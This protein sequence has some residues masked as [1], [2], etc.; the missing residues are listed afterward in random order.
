MK[1]VTAFVGS[2]RKGNTYDAVV[3]F[4]GNLKAMGDIETEIVR[5]SEY[6]LGVCRGCRLCFD[7]GE[8]HCPYKDDRDVLIEKMIASDGVVFASPNYSFQVS[9]LMKVFLDR[10]GFGFHRPRFFGKTYTSIVTQGIYGGGK[11][12]DY[13]DFVGNALGFN[14]VKGSCLMMLL[15]MTE[16]Q[17]KKIDR[18]LADQAR[19]YYTTLEKPGYPVPAV[20]L[21]VVLQDGPNEDKAG[22]RRRQSRLTP[23]IRTRAGWNLISTIPLTWEC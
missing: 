3:Q 23:T 12:V 11:L 6:K 16:K 15:P 7:K 14:T 8:E 5:L 9:G 20:D 21:P 17:Q 4:L 22:A 10:L 2:A 18:A 19:R 1:K 13:L